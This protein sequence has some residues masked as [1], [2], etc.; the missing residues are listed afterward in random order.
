[1]EIINI[2]QA[3][4]HLSRLVARVQAGE[5]I[6]L[7]KSGK[8]VARLVPIESDRRPARILGRDQGLLDMTGFD[9]PLPAEIASAFGVGEPEGPP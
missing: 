2:H 4:T 5:E 1:M 6:V 3:K 9:D 8:P 7:A